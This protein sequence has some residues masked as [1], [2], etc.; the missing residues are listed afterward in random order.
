MNNI[1]SDGMIANK[2]Q[3]QRCPQQREMFAPFKF[4]RIVNAAEMQ[5]CIFWKTEINAH[6]S[7]NWNVQQNYRAA[8]PPQSQYFWPNINMAPTVEFKFKLSNLEHWHSSFAFQWFQCW[9]FHQCNRVQQTKMNVNYKM[10]IPK[11]TI[12][13]ASEAK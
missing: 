5:S 7:R 12:Y 13:D 10:V 9:E 1:E 4:D 3:L 6:L 2:Q 11:D 8:S